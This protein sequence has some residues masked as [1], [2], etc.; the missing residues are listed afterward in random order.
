MT[1]P[2]PNRDFLVAPMLDALRTCTARQLGHVDRPVCRFPLFFGATPFA[3]AECDCTC[4]GGGQ[5]SAWIRLASLTP[6]ATSSSRNQL[7]VE[8]C[9]HGNYQVAVEIGVWRKA[10]LLDD[11]GGTAPDSVY[12]AHT[13][14]LLD[15]TAALRR[16]LQC[17]DWLQRRELP[18]SIDS[19]S[20]IGPEGGCVGVALTARIT[21]QSCACP[22]DSGGA[23]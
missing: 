8:P 21:N 13:R 4:D 23:V 20:P 10:V 16:A 5:G 1:A 7:V 19:I 14:G 17:C 15:D 6:V 22:D 3:A 18:W 2:T 12:D 11:D 9:S